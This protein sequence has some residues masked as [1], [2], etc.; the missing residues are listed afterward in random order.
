[1]KDYINPFKSERAAALT[2]EEVLKFY[3]EDR[4]YARFIRSPRN[5]FLVGERGCGKSMAL[6]YNSFE[7]YHK[8]E[9][10]NIDYSIIGVQVSKSFIFHRQE[11]LL[12][13]NE[14]RRSIIC[15]HFMVLSIM[16]E[17][18]AS[19]SKIHEI[20]EAV[21]KESEQLFQTFEYVLGIELIKEDNFFNSVKS[22]ASHEAILTQKKI[23]EYDSTGFYDNIMS[24]SSAI[25]PFIEIIKSI[26]IFRN[27]HFLL[28]FDDAQ[29]MNEYQIKILNSWI[30][31][32]DHF[33]FSFKVA[34]TKV[35]RPKL[36]TSTGGT[37][38]EGHDFTS[39]DMEKSFQNPDSDFYKLAKKI[40]EKRLETIGLHDI[41]AETFFPENPEFTKKMKECEEYVKKEAEK[42]Y[43][44]GDKKKINDHIY[45]Y[46]RAKYYR[47][48]L[49]EK[50][51]RANMPPYSGF[52]MIVAISTGI[53]RNLLEPCFFMFD[54]A[55]SDKNGKVKKVDYSKQNQIISEKS[56]EK[57]AFIENGLASSIENCSIEQA[58]QIHQLFENLMMYFRERLKYH[59]SEPRAITFTISKKNSQE[60]NKIKELLDIARKAQILYTRISRSK[61]DG[62]LEEY[63]IPD[64]LLFPAFGLDPE[65]Q[66]ARASLKAIDLWN[67]AS[68]NVRFPYNGNEHKNNDNVLTL[69][70][71]N[72]E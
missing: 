16:N 49:E 71:D 70:G 5:I 27:S 22:Y 11:Y 69:F 51:G 13:D 50:K 20:S 4:N 32:R 3:I 54:I 56:K 15:E 39:I 40:V 7:V 64:R 47:D 12:I 17:I 14:F 26:S 19:L 2:D 63:F 66:H 72:Y 29:T 38:L 24:F 8:K 42:K 31:N 55:F 25:I 10:G 61:D 46:A 6:R 9:K 30:A 60:Y 57:W 68:K 44:D 21:K 45:K 35:D 28:M 59:E 65:G 53:I 52:K 18:A 33:Y 67:A 58:K 48:R 37:I 1:M 62:K 36:I 34:T 43:P 41:N 23:N